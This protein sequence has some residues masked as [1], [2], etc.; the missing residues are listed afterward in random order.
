LVEREPLHLP[1]G[2]PG[3]AHVRPLVPRE[4]E[5]AQIAEDDRLVLGGAPLLIGVLDPEDEGPA[6]LPRPEPVEE[7]GPDAADVEV[8]GRGGGEAEAGLPG[9]H[10]PRLARIIWRASARRGLGP[11]AAPS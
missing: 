6:R 7:R 10:A 1:V 8:A 9:G 3:T 5:P 2:P 11:L 4:P